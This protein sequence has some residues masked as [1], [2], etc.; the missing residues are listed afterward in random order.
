M[1]IDFEGGQVRST[2]A[3]A[4]YAAPAETA[5]LDNVGS[6]RVGKRAGLAALDIE[7]K[8]RVAECNAPK[9]FAGTSAVPANF[10]FD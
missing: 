6:I 8:G 1:T 7:M 2:L 4:E 3:D 10:L 5:G 9:K